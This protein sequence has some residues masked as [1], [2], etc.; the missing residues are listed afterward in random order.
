VPLRAAGLEAADEDPARRLRRVLV[1][2]A[3][4]SIGRAVVAA[5]VA[6]GHAV[7]APV[8]RPP[9][10]ELAA[11]LAGADVR[12]G[13]VADP[14]SLA[15][16]VLAGERIDAVVSCLASRTGV[17]ADAWAIDHRATVAL[18]DAAASAGARRAVLVSALC[19][20]TP[21]LAFQHAKLAAEAALRDGPLAWTVVRPT[22]FFKSLS[23]QVERVRRGRPFLAIG[24]GAR[25]ACKPISDRDLAAFV[26]DVLDDPSTI[27]RVLPIGGPGEAL[28]PRDQ[29]ALLAGLLGR[30][31]ALRRVPAALLDAIAGGLALAARA[32][33]RWEA[34]AEL[35]RIGRHYATHSMLVLDPATGRPSASATP[36]TGR[37]TLAEHYAALLRRDAADARGAHAVFR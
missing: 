11:A 28:T 4:G 14:A 3:S 19:V 17:A 25:T 37:D 27:G 6:R 24:D 35:A 18:F 1:G 7:V 22:A 26:A 15:R 16:D 9:D 32:V 13:D 23:G 36:S 12:V 34:K 5:L 2:G 10:A 30:P 21:R 31:V 33:P 20:Q 29:A 8:R